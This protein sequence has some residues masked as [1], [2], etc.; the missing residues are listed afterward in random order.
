MCEGTRPL[1][2]REL[3]HTPYILWHA[4]TFIEDLRGISALLVRT[5][6]WSCALDDNKWTQIVSHAQRNRPLH[7]I[8][9]Y[10]TPLC[11]GRENN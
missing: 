3:K 5:L 8:A 9:H 10:F 11:R 4:Q 2:F 6:S 1:K 7:T